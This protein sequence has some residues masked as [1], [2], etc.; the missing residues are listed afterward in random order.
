[1]KTLL[2]VAIGM[3]G[4]LISETS[5]NKSFLKPDPL[6]TLT[7]ENT[8]V[9]ESGFESLLVTMRKNLTFEDYGNRNPIAGEFAASDLAIPI[10]E[11]DFSK[12]TPT[13]DRYWKYLSF[14]TSCYKYIK[15]ANVAISRINDITWSSTSKKNAVLA[16]AY[17]HRAYWYY[18]LVNS[19][20]DVPWSGKEVTNAKLNYE[21]Y[22]RWT[23]LN[24]IESDLDFAVQ[25]LPPTA[26]PGAISKGAGYMLLA[27]VALANLHFDTAIQAATQVING[28]YALMTQRFGVDANNL[29][30]NV[31]WDLHRPENV[32]SGQ[33]TETILATVDRPSAPPGARTSGTYSMRLYDCAFWNNVIKDSVGGL[34][35]IDAGG[36]YDTL[37]R[38]N[39]DVR[40]D[41]FYEYELWTFG[42]Q[43][44]NNTTDLRRS[45]ANWTD[46]DK[47][48]YNNPTSPNYR[49]PV[50]P[51][52]FANPF[53]SLYGFY[54]FPT[55]ITYVPQN[56]G[57]TPLGGNGDWYIFRL[58]GAYLL[59]AEAEYWEGN[60]VSAA[61]DI[62]IVRERA[63]ADPISPGQ[64]TIDFIMDERAR[65]LFAEAPRH[66]ELVR[67]SYIMAKLGI[68]G[69][70]LSNF[71]QKNYYYDRVMRDN[72]FYSQGF[73]YASNTI[74]ISPYNVLWPIPETIITANTLGTINQNIGYAGSGNNKPPITTPIN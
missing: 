5:C 56:I 14:F 15:D 21:T 17:W 67:V 46:L 23:I 36:E 66:S 42:S 47:I 6:S 20:G 34:G 62:N 73:T 38:G 65:E 61:N 71:S 35:T 30:Y 69:Y 24:K 10:F 63:H 68:D 12:L 25:W 70:S 59:R 27:K 41:P 4:F 72:I 52:Y 54:A 55:Y 60:L 26:P 1:M 49:E 44:W 8:Y 53:D 48:Y 13:D 16:E 2:K 33:N 19:Y 57:T 7:P 28:P 37:G 40:L 43:R 74:H 18:R 11:M 9:N 50:N 3:V 45:S 64:V 29:K 31:I 22:S 32:N 39:S 51:K 58:A